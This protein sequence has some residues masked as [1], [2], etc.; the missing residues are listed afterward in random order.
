MSIQHTNSRGG[1]L[2]FVV[3]LGAGIGLAL[4]MGQSKQALP[5]TDE[6]T[7]VQKSF[8]IP[9][10]TEN[11]YLN[12]RPDAQYIGSAAC[13]VC[14]PDNHKSYLLTPHSQALSDVDPTH[15][16]PDG[17]F[18][19]AASGRSYRVYHKDG[20]LRHEEMLR[21]E[22]GNEIGRTDLPVKYVVGS[23]HF[24]QSYLVEVDGFLHESPITWYTSKQKWDVSP[25]YDKPSH[26]GFERPATAECLACHAG[27]VEVN[28]GTVHQLAFQE[29][30][31]GCENCHGPGSLHQ[32]R[33]I[34]QKSFP[35]ERDLTIV[36]PAKLSR[37]LQ[38]SICA[39][40]HLSNPALVAVRGRNPHEFRPG[41]LLSDYRVHYQ[42]VGG[43]DRLTV[44]GHVEQLRQSACYQ[45]S[46]ALTCVTCHDPHRVE[47]QKDKTA[48]FREMC[49][50]CHTHQTCK[51]DMSERFAKAD[52]NCVN[53]HMPRGDTEIP[54]VSFTNHRIGH[55][56]GKSSLGTKVPELA[57]TDDIKFLEPLD[58]E[59][60]LGLAYLKVS[61]NPVYMTFSAAFRQ[62]AKELLETVTNTGMH[63]AEID[64]ALAELLWELEPSR[65]AQYSRKVLD[66]NAPPIARAMALTVLSTCDFQAH[67]YAEAITS[68]EELNRLRRIGD[69]WRL[70]GMC[71]LAQTNYPNALSAFQ[72][73]LE[74][75]PYRA[76]IHSGLAEL[77]RRQGDSKK[78]NEHREK[79][80]WLIQHRQD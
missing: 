64:L 55:H 40:C 17:S 11:S 30:A 26:A 6:A 14:H 49:L 56:R 75:R 69:D 25:G 71:H 47:N 15:G 67:N 46:P 66:Q 33:Y 13:A 78:A 42:F 31:I 38:E 53:C 10:Y 41:R 80:E 28:N 4:W 43:S 70:L 7:P 54:H 18:T 63:D 32:N 61:R 74:I 20:E 22:E 79:A 39:S 77:Y 21:T 57:T 34:R 2:L 5:V 23:G 72:H 24:T 60:N 27:R 37:P 48:F 19:H 12:T 29:K 59:R 65:A 45:R 35:G 8:P 36:N 73:A 58:Q 52:D 44:V 50:G 62:R 1:L 3:F 9:A 51:L 68:L 76:T 16:P